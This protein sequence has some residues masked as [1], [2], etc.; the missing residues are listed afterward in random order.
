MSRTAPQKGKTMR[1]ILTVGCLSIGLLASTAALTQSPKERIS[2][3]ETHSYEESTGELRR[4]YD[5]VRGASGTVDNV[6][7]VHTLRPHTFE[8]HYTLY[9]SVLH[10]PDNVLPPET[11]EALGVYTSMTNGCEYSATHHFEG[12]RRV[13]KP[14]GQLLFMELE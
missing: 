2:W 8:G 9:K 1:T 4:L 14:D 5:L 7:K 3:I 10:H 13:L 11:L 6:V 12:M